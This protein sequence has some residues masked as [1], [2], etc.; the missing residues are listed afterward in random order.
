MFEEHQN[1]AFKHEKVFILGKISFFSTQHLFKNV[2]KIM[3]KILIILF[4]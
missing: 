4:M 3:F 2:E 1:V